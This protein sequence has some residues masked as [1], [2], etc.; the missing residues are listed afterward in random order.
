MDG[1]KSFT[2]TTGSSNGS[3]RQAF[4]LSRN[5]FERISGSSR[6]ENPGSSRID[7]ELESLVPK[8]QGFLSN[9]D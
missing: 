2:D 6:N 3:G 7:T 8:G 4:C 1:A 5:F 9:I